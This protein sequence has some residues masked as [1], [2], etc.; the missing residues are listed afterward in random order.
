MI[1]NHLPWRQNYM[2]YKKI[3]PQYVNTILVVIKAH[4]KQ[5][6]EQTRSHLFIKLKQDENNFES[7]FSYNELLYV[8]QNPFALIT[9]SQFISMQQQLKIATPLWIPH[10]VTFAQQLQLLSRNIHQAENSD[11]LY[12][13]KNLFALSLIPPEQKPLDNAAQVFS[14]PEMPHLEFILIK[15]KMDHL[16]GFP[17]ESAIKSIQASIAE[18]NLDE[19]LIQVQLTGEVPLAYEE[20]LSVSKDALLAAILSFIMVIFV[21]FITLRSVVL[22]FASIFTL[23]IGLTLT[24]GFATAA[25]G[26]LNLISIAFAVLYIGLGIDFAIHLCMRYRE[27]ICE[28]SVKI[29][30]LKNTLADIGPSLFL[31]AITTSISFYAF[32]PTNFLGVSELGLISG[33]GILIGFIINLSLLPALLWLLPKPNASKHRRCFKVTLPHT[34]RKVTRYLLVLITLIILALLPLIQQ[35]HFEFDP[36]QLRDPNTDSVQAFNQLMQTRH[37]KPSHVVLLTNDPLTIQKKLQNVD[38]VESTR[39]LYNFLPNQVQLD[40]MNTELKLTMHDYINKQHHLKEI[41][42]IEIISEINK[43]LQLKQMEL[44]IQQYKKSSRAEKRRLEN[45]LQQHL[46]S[47]AN[48]LKKMAHANVTHQKTIEN[49]E[50]LPKSIQ[51]LW[52]TETGQ[53]RI[54]IYPKQDI[55]DSKQAAAFV[56][57]LKAEFPSITGLPVI[58]YEAGAAVTQAFIQAFSYALLFITFLLLFFKRQ[59]PGILW[60]LVC[61]IIASIFTVAASVTA[62]IPFNFANII[63]LPLLLGIGVDNGIHLVH[64]YHHLDKQKPLFASST[65]KAILAST[66]T[67]ICSFGNLA[68]SKHLGMASMGQLLAIGMLIMLACTLFILPL[69]L[70]LTHSEK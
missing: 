69:L 50:Q 15:P 42:F 3:F 12:L 60:I 44:W 34:S 70:H 57:S 6:L 66:M 58:Y 27:L 47:A 16:Q 53:Y 65:S 32:I 33:T 19:D 52:R 23:L 45:E 28:G 1:A 2:Q 41:D 13:T 39:S 43:P 7:V 63:A 9:A 4:N 14:D 29:N 18:L 67:T 21:L 35:V 25:I 11:H 31:C 68:F 49:I 30:A 8:K 5:L 62:D 40:A 17:G 24:A 26:Y 61:L 56:E 59:L 55:R 36:M 22:L 38:L 54:E 46:L 48:S 20:L 37:T 64:R 10:G 51:Q